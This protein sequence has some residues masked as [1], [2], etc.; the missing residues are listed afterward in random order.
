MHTNSSQKS[1]QE[2]WASYT[3]NGICHVVIYVDSPYFQTSVDAAGPTT[4]PSFKLNIFNH[5][6]S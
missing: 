6:T 4:V 2:E 3:P 1:P 5:P